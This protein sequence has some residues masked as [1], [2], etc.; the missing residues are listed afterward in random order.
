MSARHHGIKIL[1][2]TIIEVEIKST[3]PFFF[4]SHLFI[5]LL[6]VF[7]LLI[8]IS[9]LSS[10]F[11]LF[12]FIVNFSQPQTFFRL[13]IYFRSFLCE[14][15]IGLIVNRKL[16][17]RKNGFAYNSHGTMYKKKFKKRNVLFGQKNEK[18]ITKKQG[19]GKKFKMKLLRHQIHWI[20]HESIFAT[21]HIEIYLRI[22]FKHINFLLFC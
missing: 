13:S 8:F 7:M 18:S 11:I 19:I 2:R 15:T 9:R 4:L 5:L 20:I 16:N 3:G 21:I 1:P 14:I 6:P 10:L 17:E 22:C 12:Y